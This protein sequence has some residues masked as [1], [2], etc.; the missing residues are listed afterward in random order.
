MEKPQLSHSVSVPAFWYVNSTVALLQ[1]QYT[2][3][4]KGKRD[5]DMVGNVR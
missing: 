1:S 2:G 4:Y 3:E 5:A